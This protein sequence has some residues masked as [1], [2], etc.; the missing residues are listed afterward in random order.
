MSPDLQVRKMKS[1]NGDKSC[2]RSQSWSRIF[3]IQIQIQIHG[4]FYHLNNLL[5]NRIFSDFNNNNS[6]VG[7][8]SFHLFNI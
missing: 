8:A 4:F 5:N 1:I 6:I 2:P 7:E 3:K